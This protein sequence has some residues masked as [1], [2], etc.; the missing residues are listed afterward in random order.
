MFI[1]EKASIKQYDI[2]KLIKIGYFGT[3]KIM[4]EKGKYERITLSK[5]IK[6][7]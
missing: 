5:V 2:K 1:K 4:P 6:F 3:G 7:I